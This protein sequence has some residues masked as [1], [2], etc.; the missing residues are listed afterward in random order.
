[1]PPSAASS[2][3]AVVFGEQLRGTLYMPSTLSARACGVVLCNPFGYE[4]MCVHSSY[5]ALAQQLSAAGFHVLRFDYHGTGNSG[6]SGEEP[7]RVSAWLESLTAAIEFLKR[8]VGVSQIS[9]FG[10]RLGATLAAQVAT[11]R[12]DIASLVAW[13]PVVT[14]R[15]YLRELRAFRKLQDIPPLSEEVSQRDGEDFQGY[16][17]SPQTLAALNALSL[18]EATTAPAPNL[19][20]IARDDLPGMEPRWVAQLKQLG[21]QPEQCSLPGYAGMMRDPQGAEVPHAALAEIARWLE[22]THPERAQTTARLDTGPSVLELTQCDERAVRF[23]DDR[24]FGIVCTPRTSPRR[25]RP[26]VVFLNVGANHHV[27]PNRMYVVLARALAERGFQSLR[28]DVGGIS[29]SRR[30]D[31]THGVQLYSKDAIG[32]VRDAL[33]YLR[34]EHGAQRFIVVGLCSGAYLAFHITTEDRGVVAQVLLNPQTFE[35]KEG[36]SLDLSLRGSYKS[37]QHYRSALFQLSTWVDAARGRKNISGVLRVLGER[38]GQRARGDLMR[39]GARLRRRE[40]PASDVERAFR[41]AAER[42]IASLLVFSE[43]DGGRDML[44]AH[45]GP[46]GA[47]MRASAGFTFH[48]VPDADHTFTPVAAQR[49]LYSVLIAQLIARF[50]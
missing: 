28:F 35:W 8:R 21:A 20:V 34:N 17:L 44:D 23:A 13:A 3:A 27:G 24:L 49:T 46:D 19:L 18:T 36:D 14:G 41:A 48:V 39:L 32:D 5:V 43:K 37:T 40:P 25:P 50:G 38:V 15:A 10:V 11:Q 4:A 42:G 2:P 26:T 1:M 30:Q 31:G 16:L 22:R 29:D 9:L 7:D 33:S 6:G 47:R 45:L 12:T